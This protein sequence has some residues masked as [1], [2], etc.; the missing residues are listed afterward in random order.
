VRELL[1]LFRGVCDA[2]AVLHRHDP[3]W[4]H[5][6]IKPE[7]VLLSSVGGYGG[8]GAV[9][10]GC[11]IGPTPVLMDFGSVD[12]AVVRVGSR[13]EALLLQESAAEKCSM[14]YRAPEL[15]DVASDARIDARTDVWSLGCL[16][17]AMAY[18]YSPFE[19]TFDNSA[20]AAAGPGWPPRPRV[21]DCSYLRVISE[22]RFP[23]ASEPRIDE[24]VRWLLQREPQQRPNIGQ[25]LRRLDGGGGGSGSS[26]GIGGI[27]GGGGGGDGGGDG[28]GGSSADADFADFA[29]FR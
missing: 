29:S 12:D 21:S 16:L 19:C 7:N 28:G 15:F 20:A 2:V 23:A 14:A 1:R 24:L 8:V 4:A 6:D 17:F 9:G 5:R 11:G 26:G 13:R 25:V 10:G 27:G 3:P 22:V 18:G